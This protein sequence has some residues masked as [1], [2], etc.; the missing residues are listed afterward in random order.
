MT[1][2]NGCVVRVIA[3][4]GIAF[5][6][7]HATRLTCEVVPSPGLRNEYHT[8]VLFNSH[9]RFSIE[10]R[11]A[12]LMLLGQVVPPPTSPHGHTIAISRSIPQK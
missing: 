2:A 8:R 1:R 3:K 4:F 6:L 10:S 5:I 11:T 7:L 9:A 12:G